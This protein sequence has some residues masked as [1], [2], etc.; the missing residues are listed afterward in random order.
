[1]AQGIVEQVAQHPLEQQRVAAHPQIRAA[2]VQLNPL[3]FGFAAGFAAQ[4]FEQRPQGEHFQLGLYPARQGQAGVVQQR[5][6]Q[7]TELLHRGRQT[8]ADPADTRFLALFEQVLG[9]QA[10]GV[11]RLAQVMAGRREQTQ[12]ARV[13]GFGTLPRQVEQAQVEPGAALP[14]LLQVGAGTANQVGADQEQALISQLAA[15]LGQ[16]QPKR[17][18]Q[19]A[20]APGGEAYCAKRDAEQHVAEQQDQKQ[21]V[22]GHSLALGPAQVNDHRHAGAVQRI[23]GGVGEQRTAWRALRTPE[24]DE[25]S[26]HSKDAQHA[27]G[28][29]RQ[30]HRQRHQQQIEDGVD[31]L[32]DNRG[33]D[34]Q[35]Q[36]AVDALHP[37]PDEALLQL[38]NETQPPVATA[39]LRQQPA[40]FLLQVHRW[41]PARASDRLLQLG[42]L[43]VL[44]F[45]GNR[46]I[47]IDSVLVGGAGQALAQTL[48]FI[49]LVRRT[50]AVAVQ[51]G[52]LLAIGPVA[53]L[54]VALAAL[55]EQQAFDSRRIIGQSQC[56]AHLF[57]ARPLAPQP[58]AL[59]LL[60]LGLAL[61]LL[62]GAHGGGQ[63]LAQALLGI[64]F[65]LL[66]Q[67]VAGDQ[68]QTVEGVTRVGLFGTEQ[69]L[70]RARRKV[71]A[72]QLG[73]PVE[74]LLQRHQ[75]RLRLGLLGG[76]QRLLQQRQ[77]GAFVL[78]I[79]AKQA[80]Q[81]PQCRL[82]QA[83]AGIRQQGLDRGIE[84]GLIDSAEEV[85]E[86]VAQRQVELQIAGAVGLQCA[87]DLGTAQAR[88]QRRRR[89][90]RDNR[91]RR[92]TQRGAGTGCGDRW[93]R[94]GRID[95][96]HDGVWPLPVEDHSGS[97]ETEQSQQDQR[98]DRQGHATSRAGC[99]AARKRGK[100]QTP[101]FFR[102]LACWRYSETGSVQPRM[103]NRWL[104]ASTWFMW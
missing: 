70:H 24:V 98:T 90:R 20:E 34:D 103:P 36:A 58:F 50:Q 97:G 100:D 89:G 53:L 61:P 87:I 79:I 52:Q 65:I 5:L 77:A 82:L 23:G 19:Q 81:L 91:R 67:I 47:G 63:L 83:P 57:L 8:S 28:H 22:V 69:G 17:Q 26:Q 96:D 6:Q 31:Q 7:T 3:Q 27:Q 49:L 9:I 43:T 59:R 93:N 76:A 88:Q 21:A 95:R 104:I 45:G 54:P 32:E 4:A 46:I 62:T 73:Q 92:L 72:A 39:L 64:G 102:R 44:L 30:A 29:H 101:L 25:T 94:A 80:D 60:R 41:P 40:F 86:I 84:P 2:Q 38:R 99:L 51:A 1:M 18:E 11:Q 10:H 71:A 66:A 33:A 75:L 12:L 13:I 15:R 55:L 48:L 35:Q 37:V 14:V 78:Q 68:R 16:Q 74:G 42:G 85:I 56:L